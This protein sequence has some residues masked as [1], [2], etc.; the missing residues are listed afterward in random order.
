LTRHIYIGPAGWSYEDWKGIVYPSH[1]KTD[2]LELLSRMFNTVEINSSFYRPPTP[3]VTQTWMQRVRGNPQFI[4]TAKLYRRFTHERDR[5]IPSDEAI[6]K[7]GL[8]PFMKENKL[9]ALLVQFP[10]SFH[11]TPENKEVLID[12]FDRFKD[13]PLVLEVRHRSWNTPIVLGS[14]LR[15]GVGFCNLDQPRVSHSIGLTDHVTSSI[16]YLR[17]HGRNT[18][19]WFRKDTGAHRYDYLYSKEEIGQL[20]PFFHSLRN[21]ADKLFVIANNHY[22]G[23]AVANALQLQFEFLGKVPHISAGLAERY[24]QLAPIFPVWGE[25]TG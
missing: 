15:H 1:T 11:N 20:V 5:L 14:L 9:G 6:F 7:E 24:P 17:L 2:E 10:Y 12:L 19:Q 4:F 3:A 22:A 21:R 16:A 23:Q 8:D 18:E 25:K 13:Y